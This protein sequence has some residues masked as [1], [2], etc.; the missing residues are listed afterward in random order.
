LIIPAVVP[1]CAPGSGDRHLAKEGT[2]PL[3][4]SSYSFP[5]LAVFWTILEFFSS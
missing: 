4:S 1:G 3:A 5:L 2:V